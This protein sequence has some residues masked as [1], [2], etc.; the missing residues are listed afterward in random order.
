MGTVR[1]WWSFV[2]FFVWPRRFVQHATQHAIDVEVE[3]N[4]HL[5]QEMKF[6]PNG[7]KATKLREQAQRT[8]ARIHQKLRASILANLLA[9]VLILLA[10]RVSALLLPPLWP[11]TLTL[12]RVASAVLIIWAVFG[13]LGWKIQTWKGKALPEAVNWMWF[14]LTYGLGMYALFLSMIAWAR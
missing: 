7:D 10:A 1:M 14:R 9:V 13:R 11:A 12:L 3:G 2:C 5:A 4:T 6:Y 8:S